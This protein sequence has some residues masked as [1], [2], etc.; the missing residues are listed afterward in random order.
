M[1][2][3]YTIRRDI[4]FSRQTAFKSL[5][6][7]NKTRL[8]NYFLLTKEEQEEE[9]N[10][11]YYKHVYYLLLIS[12]QTISFIP[13]DSLDDQLFIEDYLDLFEI[14]IRRID[15][16]MPKKS[17]VQCTLG[18]IGERILTFLWNLTD[19]I[20][21]IPILLRTNLAENTLKWIQQS[22]SLTEKSRRAFPSILQNIARHD[23]GAEKLNQFDAIE[24]LKAYQ[25]NDISHE[26][27]ISTIE[28]LCSDRNLIEK[29]REEW[30]SKIIDF[31]DDR[32][33]INT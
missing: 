30:K 8:K 21:L 3:F 29:P 13:F 11:I 7:L 33:T 10:K 22:D 23:Q 31:D 19:R 12:S 26:I 4:Q 32:I 16:R 6:N 14:F 15:Q 17:D 27:Q 18:V 25:Q 2:Q 9:M 5:E 24:I 20:I 28:R 1:L